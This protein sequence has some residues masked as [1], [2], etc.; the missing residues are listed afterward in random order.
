MIAAAF[1][2][3]EAAESDPLEVA[4]VDELRRDRAW[5]PPLSLVADDGDLIGHVVC[6][7][8]H[9]DDVAVLALGPIGVL[10]ERQGEG[11]GTALMNAMILAAGIHGE[12]V[13]GLVGHPGFYV[14]FGFVPG[15]T[16]GVEPPDPEWGDA[17]QILTAPGTIT[18]TG[19][20]RYAAPFGVD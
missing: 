15:R 4:L 14:R 3:P 12:G 18:P 1:R 10:P 8:A 6:T 19:R 13:I 20:F 7:R 16:V 17:F 5:I 2:R 11:I 9:I